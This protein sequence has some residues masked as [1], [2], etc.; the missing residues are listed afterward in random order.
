MNALFMGNSIFT[1]RQGCHWHS[2]EGLDVVKMGEFEYVIIK[3]IEGSTNILV[4]GT[5]RVKTGP[6]IFYQ[7]FVLH[8]TQNVFESHKTLSM[9]NNFSH[10][11]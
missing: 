10:D 3:W 6:I 9:L 11:V 5:G 8:V 4:F 1:L 7:I 2:N